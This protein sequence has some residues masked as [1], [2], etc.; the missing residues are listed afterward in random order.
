MVSASV[1]P[2]DIV[3]LRK[4]FEQADQAHVLTF[5][6]DLTP[7]QQGELVEQLSGLDVERVN[8]VYRCALQ[9]EEAMKQLAAGQ[10]TIE[11]PPASRTVSVAS[12]SSEETALREIGLDAIAAGRVGVLLMAGGQGTRLG[13]SDPKGCYD[14]GLP[15]HK[16]L[17]QLQAERIR[18]LQD[19][20]AARAG[21]LQGSV[22]V[23]WFIMTSG[24]TRKPTEN[25]FKK[26][27]FFGLDSENVIFFEQGK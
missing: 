23:T 21:K 2:V 15:S 27:A 4:K 14:I 12:G 5:W 18:R 19:L 8:D 20:A 16:S 9:G 3:A 10:H 7:D 13:S 26:N 24:P 1:E 25:F 11:P 6:D 17:F 22:I